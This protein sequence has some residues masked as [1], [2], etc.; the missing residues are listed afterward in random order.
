MLNPLSR[1]VYQL[2]LMQTDTVLDIL[3]EMHIF[4]NAE[5]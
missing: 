5:V 1:V 3:I 2:C 4:L